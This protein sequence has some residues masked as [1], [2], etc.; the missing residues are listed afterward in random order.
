MNDVQQ[1]LLAW[2]GRGFLAF[3]V[4]SLLWRQLWVR[5]TLA[6]VRDADVLALVGCLDALV[7]QIKR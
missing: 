6:F 1:V 4:A 5:L 2:L 7:A 3:A